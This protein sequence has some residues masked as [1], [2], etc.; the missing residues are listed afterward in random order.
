MLERATLAKYLNYIPTADKSQ[1]LQVRKKDT[2]KIYAMKVLDK[3]SIIEN[4][5]LDHT[6]TERNILQVRHPL[7][8]VTIVRISC[9]RFSCICTTHSKVWTRFSLSWIS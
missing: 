6:L 3:K 9:I 5:E 7:S 1:V 2:K 4:D 8:Q